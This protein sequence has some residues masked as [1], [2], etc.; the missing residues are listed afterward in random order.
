MHSLPKTIFRSLA[1]AV[2][3]SALTALP[4]LAATH[5]WAT[6]TPLQREALTPLAQQ[7]DNLPEQQQNKL[8]GTTK[9][10]SSLTPLQRE[11][12]Q[13][14][15]TEWSKLTPAQRQRAREKYRALSKVPPEKREAIKQMAKQRELEKSGTGAASPADTAPR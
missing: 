2:C 6:L 11:R 9:S 8:L 14:R 15:L 12:F 7:W 5:P 1:I 3:C 13:A 10:Y 4:A